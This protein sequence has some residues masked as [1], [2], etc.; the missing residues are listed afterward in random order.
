MK[1]QILPDMENTRWGRRK[2]LMSAAAGLAAVGAGVGIVGC[3]GGTHS[4]A[5]SAGGPSG[6]PKRGGTL[7]LGGQGGASTDTL[8]GQNPLT[9]TDFCRSFQLFDQLVTLDAKG[10][11]Q[12]SLAK[13]ITPNKDGTQWTITLP[14]GITTHRGKPFTADD[15]LYSFNRIVQNKY[16][17]AASMGPINL[18]S[19]KVVDPTTLLVAYDKPYAILPEV[20]SLG[21]MTVVPRD[22]DAKNPDGTGPFKYQSFTPGVASTFV[23]HDNYW[24]S[25]LPHLDGVVTTNMA[26]ETSQVNALQSG[27]LDVINFLSAAS[28]T[29]LQS[30]GMH[31]NVSNTG[32]FGPFTMRVDQ[33]PYDDVRVRQALRLMVNR[34]EMVNQVFGGKGRVGNDVF[35]IYDKAFPADLPQRE[36]DI[37]QAK[38]LLKSAGAQDLVIQLVTTPN[39]PG[40][41]NA[42]QVFA[43]QAKK[44]GVTVNIVQQ[45]PTDYFANS[46]LKTTFSQDYWQTLPF[47]VTAGQDAAGPDAPFNATKFNDPEYNALYAQAIAELDEAKRTDLIHQMAHI[48]YD[49]GAN[50]IP[51]FFPTIDASAS[52]TGGIGES[53]NGYSPGGNDFTDFWL[54]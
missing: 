11:P 2:F 36:Q 44:A 49:R 10:Q 54:A 39:A 32:G 34:Q 48:D 43:T 47:L 8:D 35:G 14:A 31:V 19:S 6:A 41:I 9:N 17:G 5:A 22:F 15:V 29:A 27:Q 30:G 52:M 23:R 24:R 1:P 4:G 26:D 38:S 7:R 25:D 3:A 16:P 20:L 37:D 12:L 21:Y 18:A 40:M 45:T 42:A 13:S 28:V 50:I 33:K 46:Y 53:A 51:Y